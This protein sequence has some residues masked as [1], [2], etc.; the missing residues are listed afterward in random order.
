MKKLMKNVAV[1]ALAAAVAVGS[2]TGVSAAVKSLSLIHIQ[3]CIRDRVRTT[4]LANLEASNKLFVELVEKAHAHGIK[5]IIDGVFNHCGSFNKWM[6]KEKFY[7]KNKNYKSG[8][9]IS[10][11]SPYNLY[12]KFLED[13]WPDNNSFEGWWG[14]DTLPKLNYE[15]SKELC[16]YIIE[17]GKKWV[18]PPYNVDAVSYTHLSVSPKLVWRNV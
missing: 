3:M 7:T 16:D 13:R 17:V 14:F 18:S 8:A 4:D 1:L 11:D 15:G 5:I 2:V 12:F 6:D 9:Y 10:K